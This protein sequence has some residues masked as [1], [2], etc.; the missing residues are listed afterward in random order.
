MI[1]YL[2]HLHGKSCCRKHFHQLN[3]LRGQFPRF[4]LIDVVIN[5]AKRERTLF[6]ETSHASSILLINL[7]KETS[8]CVHICS[9]AVRYGQRRCRMCGIKMFEKFPAYFAFILAPSAA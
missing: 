2:H 5:E 3:L 9:F 4:S 7:K 1:H 8:I 6:A